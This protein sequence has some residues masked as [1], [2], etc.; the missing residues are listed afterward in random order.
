MTQTPTGQFVVATGFRDPQAG[1]GPHWG[2]REG[3]APHGRGGRGQPL[4]HSPGIA[5][6]IQNLGTQATVSIV[7]R[8]RADDPTDPDVVRE[9]LIEA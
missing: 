7:F 8:D 2:R 5:H 1:A 4:Q 9:V 3:P 6:A